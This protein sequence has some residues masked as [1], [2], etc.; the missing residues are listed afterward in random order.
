MGANLVLDFFVFSYYLADAP[1]ATKV[2]SEIKNSSKSKLL[3]ENGN[4]KQSK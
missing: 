2:G 3:I 4:K 1:P